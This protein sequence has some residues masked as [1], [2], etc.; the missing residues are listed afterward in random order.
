MGNRFESIKVSLSGAA[1]QD[2]KAIRLS[3]HLAR[4]LR[5][6]QISLYEGFLLNLEVLRIE[7]VTYSMT[8]PGSHA[9]SAGQCLDL[10]NQYLLSEFFREL[11][12]SERVKS[13]A[14]EAS[15]ATQPIPDHYI[16]GDFLRFFERPVNTEYLHLLSRIRSSY[17]SQDEADGPFHVERFPFLYHSPEDLL[18][19]QG[20][21]EP[22]SGELLSKDTGWDLDELL[23]SLTE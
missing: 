3:R 11:Q 2:L 7:A 23:V 17:S 10:L 21:R 22:A 15:R 16:L 19:A 14:I 5:E 4:L 18:L 1:N 6:D 13:W 12:T 8:V 20:Q 9:P